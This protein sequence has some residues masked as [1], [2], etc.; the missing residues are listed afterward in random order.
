MNS[1]VKKVM[2]S[3]AGAA[4]GYAYYY[5]VGCSTGTCPI[6][7]NAYA[8]AGYGA[9]VGMVLGWGNTRSGN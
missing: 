9:V 3:V 1:L 4:A 8:S 5:F 7:S 6:T 2:F